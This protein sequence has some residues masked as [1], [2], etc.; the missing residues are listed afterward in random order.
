MWISWLRAKNLL[1]FINV[2]YTLYVNTLL[3]IR[4]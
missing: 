1:I 3:N 4:K 2:I